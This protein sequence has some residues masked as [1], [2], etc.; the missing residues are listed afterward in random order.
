M[1]REYHKDNDH[2]PCTCHLQLNEIACKNC[3]AAGKIESILK[4]QKR[5]TYKGDPTVP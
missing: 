1:T 4:R 3:L 5:K 2:V